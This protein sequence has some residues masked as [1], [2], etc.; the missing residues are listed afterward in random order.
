LHGVMAVLLAWTPGEAEEH[1]WVRG[2]LGSEGEKTD[3]GGAM[4][5]STVLR[6]VGNVRPSSPR[7]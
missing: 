6:Q 5:P 1:L 7:A 3:A 4:V 2:V